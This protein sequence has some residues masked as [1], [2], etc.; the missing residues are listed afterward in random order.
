VPALTAPVVSVAWTTPASHRRALA[1]AG[2]EVRPRRTD[3]G[4]SRLGALWLA[5]A[6]AVRAVV[7][8]RRAPALIVLTAGTEA[9]VAAALLRL[10][11]RRRLVVVDYLPPDSSRAIRYRA[12]V[13]RRVDAWG[14]LRSAEP[15]MYARRLGLDAGRSHVV[16]FA[17]T[18]TPDEAAAVVPAP[19]LD[20]PYVYAAGATRRDWATLAAAAPSI[21]APVVVSARAEHGAVLDGVANCTRVDL[22]DPSRGLALAAAAAVVVVPFA[23]T[24]LPTGPVVL[25][26]AMALGRPVVATATTAAVDYVHDGVDGLLVAP[27]DAD[28][29]TAAVNRVLAD[30]ALAARL[31]AAA[32]EAAATTWSATRF[33]NRIRALV[34]AAGGRP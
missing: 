13:L 2:F 23:D 24:E 12:R 14:C 30:P 11:P 27:G 3:W 32:R 21:A 1:E 22:A 10:H 17:P 9:L 7:A 25:L 6:D 16:G 4:R 34:D 20:G 26:D 31:G 29:L 8:A 19:A 18:V 28:A 33:A 5:V 15:A